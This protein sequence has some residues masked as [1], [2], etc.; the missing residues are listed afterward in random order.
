MDTINV[1]NA[2]LAGGIVG[3]LLSTI[4]LLLVLTLPQRLMIYFANSIAHSLDVTSIASA[5]ISFPQAAVGV[6]GA[7][8]IGGFI[9]AVF[10]WSYNGL[11]GKGGLQ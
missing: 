2:S 7:F 10:A 8:A 9:G 4:C 3:A 11:G 5:A 1:R 6:I